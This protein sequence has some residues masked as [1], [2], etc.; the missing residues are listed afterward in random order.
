MVS[1]RKEYSADFRKIVVKLN[2]DGLSM[3]EISRTLDIP[4][5]SVQK[6]INK[7][8]KQGIL[9][10]MTG[11]GR[12]RITTKA[13]DRFIR[14]TIKMDRRK[15]AVDFAFELESIMAKKMSPQTIRNRM[16][17]V[18]I[19][20]RIARNKPFINERNRKKRLT[21]AK[22]Y[23]NIENNFWERVIWSDESKFTLFGTNGI[24]RVW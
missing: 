5:S 1:N 4:K 12:K 10:N 13:E 22:K 6:I 17:E 23:K 7:F 8:Q 21:W 20:G 15:S 9:V 16:H 19:Y 11:R 3:G 14:R 24:V 2:Q 18:G